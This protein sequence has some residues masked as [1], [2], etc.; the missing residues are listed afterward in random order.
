MNII[1][2]GISHSRVIVGFLVFIL[3][4][5]TI[6]YI[7]IPK[8]AT[9]DVN[10]PFIY[11]SLT[12]KGISPDDSERLL[13]KP[14]EDEV[15]NVEGVK[16]ELGDVLFHLAFQINVGEEGGNFEEQEV[17][18]VVI[19][20]L[21]RRHPHVFGDESSLSPEEA[22]RSWDDVKKNER[23]GAPESLLDTVPRTFP[24]LFYA[25]VLQER[26]S[27]IGFDWEDVRDVLGKVAEE[28]DE[29]RDAETAHQREAELGDILFSIV[30]VSRWLNLDAEAALRGA[31]ERFRMRFEVMEQLN[32]ESGASIENMS[33]KEKE[34]LWER[35]K[36]QLG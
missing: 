15:K 33:L 11:I 29:L 28:L 16:E 4:S 36:A 18:G 32:R 13:V 5:G 19:D 3:I 34:G 10:I 24:A 23:G 6:S 26:V 9:P 8:E 22:I 14:I 20:K 30:N 17:L 25:Q 12:Q 21:V 27:R 1:D 7:T 35:A 2:Y 31:D